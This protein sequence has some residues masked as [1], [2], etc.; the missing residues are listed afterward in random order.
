MR[1]LCL[2]LRIVKKMFGV[3]Q[4]CMPKFPR[5][6]QTRIQELSKL[7]VAIG[8][9]QIELKQGRIT[10]TLQNGSDPVLSCV[11]RDS[12]ATNEQLIVEFWYGE[13][14]LKLQELDRKRLSHNFWQ[15]YIERDENSVVTFTFA[16]VATLTANDITASKSFIFNITEPR[17]KDVPIDGLVTWF[18][19]L[20]K[21]QLVTWLG[22]MLNSIG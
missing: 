19:C 18:Q 6:M 9:S 2:Y 22:R 12:S 20:E 16:K 21:R 15:I 3:V 11:I 1:L 7:R 17:V 13:E 8:F 14:I 5:A 10:F 4:R